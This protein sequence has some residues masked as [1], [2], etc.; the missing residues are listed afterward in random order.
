M[1]KQIRRKKRHPTPS[2][3]GAERCAGFFDVIDPLKD[4]VAVEKLNA[5]QV[6]AFFFGGIPWGVAL[7]R[8][9]DGIKSCVF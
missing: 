3:Q 1:K 4:L 6:L 5:P 8:T 9:Q 2:A 7:P